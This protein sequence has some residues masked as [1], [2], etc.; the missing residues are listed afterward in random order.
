MRNKKECQ[1]CGKHV[2]RTKR[3]GL[4]WNCSQVK[5][6]DAK[7]E[8]SHVSRMA[9]RDAIRDSWDDKTRAERRAYRTLIWDGDCWGNYTWMPAECSIMLGREKPIEEEEGEIPDLEDYWQDGL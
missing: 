7:V 4:C 8:R 6:N 1:G 5:V 2:K 9:R 3:D